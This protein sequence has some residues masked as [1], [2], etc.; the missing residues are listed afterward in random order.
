VVQTV[1][2]NTSHSI[3]AY[4]SCSKRFNLQHIIDFLHRKNIRL[5]CS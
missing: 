3:E 1:Q 5:L 2:H 4:A